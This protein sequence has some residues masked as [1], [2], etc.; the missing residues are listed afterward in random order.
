M[1]KKKMSNKKLF[2]E[3]KKAQK[4]PKFMRDLNKFIKFTSGN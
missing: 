3:I 1:K 4:D 2:E